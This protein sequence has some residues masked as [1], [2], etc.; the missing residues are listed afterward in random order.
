[1]S[2]APQNDSGGT[3]SNGTPYDPTFFGGQRDGS[4]RSARIVVPFLM[5]L[6]RPASVV[7]FG[8]GCGPWLKA[9]QEAGVQTLR[10]YDGDYVDRKQLMIPGECFI[11]CDLT[12]RIELDR[13]YDLAMSLEVGE[14]L[15]EAS[16]AS[17]VQTI[18]KAAPVALFSAAIPMQDGT[19]HINEQ[20]PDYWAALFA[21]SSFVFLDALRMRFWNEPRIEWWYAQ[22]MLLFAEPALARLIAGRCT[23]VPSPDGMPARLVHPTHLQWKTADLAY[24]TKRRENPGLKDIVQGTP[25]AVRRHLAHRL[26]RRKN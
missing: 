14:H 12:R 26:G 2:D 15:P 8:C 23:V 11:N 25:G 19:A 24:E 10:G 16:A 9:F 6:L 3:A 17:F 7:D 5:D 13:R 21:R 18:C 22:N 4:L 20:W 1:M